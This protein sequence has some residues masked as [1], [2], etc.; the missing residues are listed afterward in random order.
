MIWVTDLERTLIDAIQN[1]SLCLGIANVLRAWRIGARDWNLDRLIA[2]AEQLEAGPVMRQRVG[3]L[4]EALGGRHPTLDQ[5]RDRRER[6]GSLKLV[7]ANPYSSSFD[8]RWNISINV[9]QAA[10]GELAE[11]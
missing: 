6:G 8:P 2:H 7:A 5:W 11:E 9:P 3:F 10:L 4:V 1:P